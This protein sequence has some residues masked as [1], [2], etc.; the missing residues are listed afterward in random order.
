MSHI[1]LINNTN[2][3]VRLAVFQKPVVNPTL[4]TIA[5][6]IAA[7]PP[8]GRSVVEIPS[9]F[10]LE[11]R[12]SSDPTRPDNLDTAARPARFNET[13]ASFRIQCVSSQDR[14]ADGAVINQVF[15]DLVM[16]EVRVVNHF[17]VG[18]EAAILRGADPIY[19][20]QVIWPGGL[21]MEDVRASLY[22][23]VIS[24]FTYKGQRLV[25]EEI[26]LTQTEVLEGDALIVTG[27]MWTGYALEKA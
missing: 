18:V 14:R 17:N 13:S 26:S 27:S 24:Q 20:P 15:T 6:Q 21:F 3:T 11:V 1:T 4:E 22:V 19:P 16:N 8:G 12:Y 23:A 9:D 10:G 25:Q 7:P 5:W 2:E